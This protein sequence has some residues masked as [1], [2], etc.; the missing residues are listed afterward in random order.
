MQTER[1]LNKISGEWET[2]VISTF[3]PLVFYI[4]EFYCPELVIR[5]DHEAIV[6]SLPPGFWLNIGKRE[7]FCWGIRFGKNFRTFLG[8]KFSRNGHG[9]IFTPHYEVVPGMSIPEDTS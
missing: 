4:L 5:S 8:T 1:C 3:K 7:V 6:C 2:Q 9:N